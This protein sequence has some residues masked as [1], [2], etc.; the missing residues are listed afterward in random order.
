M[1][2]LSVKQVK[3]LAAKRKGWKVAGGKAL[4]LELS[5]QDFPAAVEFI[6]AVAQ[7]AE[8]MGHHPDLHL[9]DYRKL[10]IVLSTHSAGGLTTN[11]FTLAQK[12]DALPRKLQQGK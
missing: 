3:D 10:A 1:N 6:H 4:R 12:I 2:K 8:S 9:T 7:E 5:M 11:D